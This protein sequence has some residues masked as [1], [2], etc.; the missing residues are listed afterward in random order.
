MWDQSG[1]NIPHYDS[2]ICIYNCSE[3]LIIDCYAGCPEGSPCLKLGLV[4]F[5][6]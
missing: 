5:S 2:D 3:L 4:S 6:W 1:K